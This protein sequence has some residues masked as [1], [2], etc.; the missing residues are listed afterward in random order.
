MQDDDRP[1]VSVEAAQ[2]AIDDLAIDHGCGEIGDRWRVDSGDLY[3]DR[4]S[5]S[6]TDGLE[7]AVDGQPIQPSIEV[8]GITQLAEIPP[9]LRQPVL[10]RV[11]C[12]LGVA[13]DE[14]SGRVEPSDRPPNERRKGVVVAAASAFDE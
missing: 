5:P 9:G 11:A 12:E 2:D 4:T 7:A 3:L 1:A 14:A 8:V 6:T 13:E 10:N